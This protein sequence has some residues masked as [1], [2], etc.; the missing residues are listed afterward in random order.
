M[1]NSQNIVVS[2]ECAKK[3]K[4]AV[5][6]QD[7]TNCFFWVGGRSN[8]DQPWKVEDWRVVD[9]KLRFQAWQSDIPCAA[10]TAEEILRRL[11]AELRDPKSRRLSPLTLFVDGERWIAEYPFFTLIAGVP[12]LTLCHALADMWIC[13]K[14]NNLLPSE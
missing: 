12:G 10:P 1:T 2:L 13:L 11:P 7:S 9:S 6:P 3:L 14:E 5:W 8:P 4:E